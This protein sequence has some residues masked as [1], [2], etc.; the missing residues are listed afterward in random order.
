MFWDV[1]MFVIVF[2][3]DSHASNGAAILAAL[4]FAV[5]NYISPRL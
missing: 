5:E 2:T 3:F 1:I 4:Q